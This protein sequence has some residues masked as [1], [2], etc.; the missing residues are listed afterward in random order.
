MDGQYWPALGRNCTFRNS[1]LLHAARLSRL[2][3]AA[4]ISASVTPGRR[5]ARNSS[6][7]ISR[8]HARRLSA[9][10]GRRLGLS[11]GDADRSTNSSAVRPHAHASVLAEGKRGRSGM[12]LRASNNTPGTGSFSAD[13]EPR[14]GVVFYALRQG[15]KKPALLQSVWVIGGAFDDPMMDF[16][17]ISPVSDDGCLKCGPS[18]LP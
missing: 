15:E 7:S 8:R 12:A 18:E 11:H 13:P 14:P 5:T 17:G 9:W 2:S 1:P 3:A 6:P 4:G 10:L 16:Q